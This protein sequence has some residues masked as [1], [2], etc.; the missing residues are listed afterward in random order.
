MRICQLLLAAYEQEAVVGA[1]FRQLVHWEPDEQ[2]SSYYGEWLRAGVAK[3]DVMLEILHLPEASALYVLPPPDAEEERVTIAH[4][5]QYLM[6]LRDEDFVSELYRELLYREADP[7]GFW[8]QLDALRQ[9]VHRLQ[10]ISGFLSSE[11][12]HTLL[13]RRHVFSARILDHFL[14][15]LQ[16]AGYS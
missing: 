11:E 1:L 12:W 6:V 10:L 15:S 7:S 16:G 13:D 14:H 2:T 8:I 3:N 5:L 4:R 9:G